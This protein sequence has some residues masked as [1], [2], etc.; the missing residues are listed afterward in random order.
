MQ[1]Y[2]LNSITQILK[3]LSA[4]EQVRMFCFLRVSVNTLLK[5]KACLLTCC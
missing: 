4:L 5:D 3:L 2:C 1:L